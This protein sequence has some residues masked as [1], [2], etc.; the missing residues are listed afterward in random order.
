MTPPGIE[1]ATFRFV[2][3]HLNHY[4]TAVPSFAVDRSMYH[5]PNANIDTGSHYN[6]GALANTPIYVPLVLTRMIKI[7]QF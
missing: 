2:A 5:P 3:Q 7:L 1:P 4:A 6:K